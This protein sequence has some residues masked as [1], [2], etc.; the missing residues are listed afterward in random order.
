MATDRPSGPGAFPLILR[1]RRFACLHRTARMPHYLVEIFKRPSLAS[2]CAGAAADLLL[3]TITPRMSAIRAQSSKAVGLLPANSR[4][5]A[6]GQQSALLGRR[7]SLAPSP[8]ADMPLQSP[9]AGRD[10]L[11][12]VR[13]LRFVWVSERMDANRPTHA[14]PKGQVGRCRWRCRRISIRSTTQGRER[15]DAAGGRVRRSADR[16]L[17]PPGRQAERGAVK[18]S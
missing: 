12:S 13:F 2:R 1:C 6:V 4:R 8:E 9:I 17:H 3:V 10:S 7:A 16:S 15:I 5:K 11:P 18:R 14:G